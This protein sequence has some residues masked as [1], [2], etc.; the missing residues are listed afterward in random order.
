MILILNTSGGGSVNTVN[1]T[2]V[3][4]LRAAGLKATRQRLAV[5]DALADRPETVT[6]QELHAQMRKGVARPGLATV[7]RTLSALAAAGEVDTFT[8]DGEQAFKLCGG[9]HHHHLVCEACGVV[10]EVRG[11]EVEDWVSRVARKRGFTVSGHTADI[12]GTCRD[13]APKKTQVR[14]SRKATSRST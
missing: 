10:Q 7:Y 3:T 12:F 1:P 5:L 6:A 8:R 4:S 11:R 14:N 2:H 13:C 9:H